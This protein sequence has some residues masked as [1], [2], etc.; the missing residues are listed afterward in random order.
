[1]HIFPPQNIHEPLSQIEDEYLFG[2][3]PTPGI[4][5]VWANCEGLA[6]IWRREGEHVITQ[7]NTFAPGFLP[8]RYKICTDYSLTL[9]QQR[10]TLTVGASSW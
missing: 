9:R 2:W 8:L 3:D 10:L 5:S 1:M 4:I 6:I 7:G